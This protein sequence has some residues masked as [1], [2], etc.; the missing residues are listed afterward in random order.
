MPPEQRR[1]MTGRRS[2]IAGPAAPG[3]LPMSPGDAPTSFSRRVTRA[4][5]QNTPRRRAM[6]CSRRATKAPRWLPTLT[7]R[8]RACAGAPSPASARWWSP[9]AAWAHGPGS[10]SHAIGIGR[11]YA[12]TGRRLASAMWSC[13]LSL[14]ASSI[15]GA[16]WAAL[17]RPMS[18]GDMAR[19]SVQLAGTSGDA[20]RRYLGRTPAG[21]S[22]RPPKHQP[23]AIVRVLA[24]HSGRAVGG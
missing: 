19:R 12:R 22:P 17:D 18:Q 4:R 21:Y 10:L 3:A 15:A 9:I 1:P 6:R 7:R 14:T 16:L 13:E 20:G 11:M 2:S 5:P 24:Q 23:R 8:S